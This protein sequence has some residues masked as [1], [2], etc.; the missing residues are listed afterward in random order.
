MAASFVMRPP[1][2]PVECKWKS[3][4]ST[5]PPPIKG[6]RKPHKVRSLLKAT[7]A[8]KRAADPAKCGVTIRD[9][10]RKVF[11]RVVPGISRLI[12]RLGA[13]R[14]ASN[15][16]P[17]LHTRLFQY[18][19]EIQGPTSFTRTAQPG[20]FGCYDGKDVFILDVFSRWRCWKA[21]VV[22]LERTSVSA[23]TFSLVRYAK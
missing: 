8:R 9:V 18:E 16:T 15:L 10:R 11:H 17:L 20:L 13:G 4:V 14:V 1:A 3:R 7:V 23:Y 5:R 19:P 21:D 22:P 12:E 6:N 2:T